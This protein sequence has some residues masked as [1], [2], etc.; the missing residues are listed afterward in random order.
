[1]VGGLLLIATALFVN[2]KRDMGHMGDTNTVYI[3]VVVTG[4]V[5]GG[6]IGG[7]FEKF[8]IQTF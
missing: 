6:F 3:W 8:K 2:A 7:S 4:I 5:V 1:V